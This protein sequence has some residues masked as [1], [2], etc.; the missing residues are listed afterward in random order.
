MP[1]APALIG[2]RNF[3]GLCV[4]SAGTTGTGF[5]RTKRYSPY[6]ISIGPESILI[7]DLRVICICLEPSLNPIISNYSITDLLCK[8]NWVMLTNFLRLLSS[9]LGRSFSRRMHPP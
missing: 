9:L 3:T 6:G 2:T 5:M 7:L 4:L 8:G 1:I